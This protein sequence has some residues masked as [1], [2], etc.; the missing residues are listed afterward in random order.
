MKPLVLYCKSYST[1]LRRLVRLAQSVEQFNTENIP[2]YVSVPE[3][4]LPLF[5]EHLCGLKVQLLADEEILHASP[6][7]I[8]QQVLDL[9][10]GLSQQIIKSEFWRLGLSDA[11]LCLDSD[12][13]FIRPFGLEDY[14]NTDGTPYTVITEAHDLLEQSLFKGKAQIIGNFYNEAR[15]VQSIFG[16]KGKN[17]SFGPM[18]MVWHK[19][20]WNTLDTDFLIPNQMNFLDAIKASPMESRWYGESL[21][22][23]KPI[24]I[25][26]TEPFFKVYH[27]AWQ[28]D[29]D[30]KNNID[31]KKLCQIY[32]G[33]I[34]QSAW[35]KNMDWPAE[36]GGILSKFS[37]R[38]KRKLGKI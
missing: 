34:Y 21:M 37:R 13:F 20:V 35:E 18:P 28:L 12:A 15:Q 11:Y 16:R 27:Y 4:E 31:S 10:G 33:I 17:Y 29:L 32:T 19:N 1:D 23:F 6:R 5:R 24:E 25:L 2:F 26:P 30:T 38:I 8:P 36:H 7:I 3:V 9:P 14:I 22:K